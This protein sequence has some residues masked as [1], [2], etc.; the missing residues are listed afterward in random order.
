MERIAKN[1]TLWAV[2][3]ALF[4]ACSPEMGDKPD[5]AIA[6]LQ[7]TLGV[8]KGS[9]GTRMQETEY[10]TSFTGDEQIGVFALKTS[11]NTILDNNVPYKYNATTSSWEPVNT[12]NQ[13][14]VYGSGVT[15]YAYYPYSSSMDGK[16][17]IA[18]IAAAFALPQDQS[19]YAKYTSAD[20]MTATGVLANNTL[21][22]AFA[23]ALSLIEIE[24]DETTNTSAPYDPNPAFHGTIPYKMPDGVFRYLVP[25]AIATE[26][27]FD[28]GP[29]DNRYSFQKS[30]TADM[31]GVGSY[32]RVK[33]PFVNN[34]VEFNTGNYAAALGTVSKVIINGNEYTTSPVSGNSSQYTVNWLRSF[35]DALT[36]LDIY[37]T[38]NLAEAGQKEQLLVS[39]TV[40]NVTVDTGTS[41]LTVP[42]SK[43]GMEG[44][45]TS[46]AAPYQVT[47]PPQLRGVG[48]E[49]TDNGNAETEYYEQKNHLDLNAYTNWKPV[50]S[51]LLYDGKH[52]QVRN[53]KSTQGG[54][55]SY[56][57]GTIQNVHLASGEITKNGESVGGIVYE[58]S[59][60]STFLYNCSN[61]ANITAKKNVGGIA[62]GGG[63]S[64]FMHCKNSGKI[65]GRNVGGITGFV[66][67]GDTKTRFCY[68]IGEIY[69]NDSSGQDGSGGLSGLA[70]GR[71]DYCYSTGRVWSID[72]ASTYVGSLWG[73]VT[74]DQRVFNCWA[75][76]KP[77]SG[78]TDHPS[79][80]NWAYL[81]DA[82]NNKWPVYSSGTGDG[83]TSDHWAPFVS[84]EY[85]KLLWEAEYEAKSLLP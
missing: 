46:A 67:D 35:P 1:I 7:V 15:Y 17:S 65:S 78:Q 31:V 58:S 24:I 70:W 41:T 14:L 9:T 64:T 75:N 69:V 40:A 20:L 55:F 19:T 32:V 81:F 23:H 47:T 57:G 28:Y 11:N 8:F 72:P 34:V 38:D 30:L 22:F 27:T 52:Y 44:A 84:G 10:Q 53:L 18:E 79:N 3:V 33:A 29:A 4:T 37:I 6:H 12:A 66:F 60:S 26:I 49:G 76:V 50:K 62:G 68:N 36:S 5:G 61:A 85:P 45:G 73:S 80:N 13:A 59:G 43:G 42:L 51:G 63:A 82:A 16:K 83:W 21:S 25:P 48:L 77:F 39:A 74:A 56:N 54:I 2:L 71:T